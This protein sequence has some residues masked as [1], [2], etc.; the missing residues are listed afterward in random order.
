MVR[1]YSIDLQVNEQSKHPMLY[2]TQFDILF[3]LTMSSDH[4]HHFLQHYYNH[5]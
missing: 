2:Q 1:Y 5:L 4:Q 3:D